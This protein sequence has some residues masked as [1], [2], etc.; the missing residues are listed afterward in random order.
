MPVAHRTLQLATNTRAIL[1][2]LHV[3]TGYLEVRPMAIG[4]SAYE[5]ML[6]LKTFVKEWGDLL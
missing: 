5:T 6:M 4:V 3:D 2:K 1:I